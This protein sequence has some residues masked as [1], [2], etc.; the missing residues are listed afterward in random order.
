GGGRPDAG[1]GRGGGGGTNGY[2]P[3]VQYQPRPASVTARR[4]TNTVRHSRLAAAA[5]GRIPGRPAGRAPRPPAALPPRS[6]SGPPWPRDSLGSTPAMMPALRRPAT[7]R[8][9]AAAPLPARHRNHVVDCAVY[10][11]GVRQP[12]TPTLEDAIA[13]ARAHDGTAFAWIGLHEP[14]G[15]EFA[16]LA[17]HLGLHPLAVEDAVQ[18]HQRPK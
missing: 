3:P 12:G 2:Q 8:A 11:D 17:E 15:A 7:R 1:G 6:A 14:D 18:A 4:L 9:R 13:Q 10:L 16:G 5:L